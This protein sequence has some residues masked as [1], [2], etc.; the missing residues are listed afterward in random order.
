ML[1]LNSVHVQDGMD[2]NSFMK[3]LDERFR[4]SKGYF[5][6]NL[7]DCFRQVAEKESI[8]FLHVLENKRI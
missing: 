2:K 7:K 3:N 1:L 5:C 6:P 4:S 8:A